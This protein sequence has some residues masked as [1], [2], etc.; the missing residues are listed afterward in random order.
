V[1]AL[2][3]NVFGAV[4]NAFVV[5]V[6]ACT[7]G[8]SSDAVLI[9]RSRLEPE[10]FGAIFDR[11]FFVVHRY[12]VRRIGKTRADDLASQT[13]LV[14]FGRRAAFDETVASARPWLLG[15][16]TNLVRNEL[17]SERR[18]LR[19]IARLDLESATELGDDVERTIARWELGGEA[20]RIA[21]AL[22]ALGRDQRD[23]LLLHAWGELSHEEIA[24][25]LGVQLGTVRSRLSRARKRLRRELGDCITGEALPV[26]EDSR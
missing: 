17:R 13:F 12:L 6:H 22:A 15:I 14:A 3:G 5:A 2:R 25:A 1:A 11:H 19:A 23:V 16:A 26:M 4:D 21:A 9:A 8:A 7:V 24:S 20:S 10:A 18:L